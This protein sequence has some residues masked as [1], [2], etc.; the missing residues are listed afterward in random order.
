MD[1]SAR[2][3]TRRLPNVQRRPHGSGDGWVDGPQGR[4]WGLFGAAGLAVVTPRFGLLLQHRADWSHFGGTWGIP[5]GARKEGETAEQAALR[6]SNEEAGVPLDGV[7]VFGTEV[8]DLGYW[9]YTTV[10]AIADE[11]FAPVIADAESADLRWV[12]LDRIT[13]LPLHPGLERS[14]SGLVGRIRVELTRANH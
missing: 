1:E 5:G 13:E 6:E 10:L 14:W 11:P 2:P 7:R 12:D 4:Y 3:E 8:F 9:S